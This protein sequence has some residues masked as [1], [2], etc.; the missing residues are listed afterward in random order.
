MIFGQTTIQILY[1]SESILNHDEIERLFPSDFDIRNQIISEASKQ[2]EYSLIIKNDFS[3]FMENSKLYNQLQDNSSKID[4]G[5]E[6]ARLFK[7]LNNKI[8]YEEKSLNKTYLVKDSLPNFKWK[9]LNE[10]KKWGELE[11]KKATFVNEKDSTEIIAWFAP[12]IRI[13]DGPE[14]YN[15]LPGLII[16]LQINYLRNSNPDIVKSY[17]YKANKIEFESI[18]DIVLP[19]KLKILSREEFQKLE[20]NFNQKTIDIISGGVERD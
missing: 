4:F 17:F 13:F 2:R 11:L 1:Q 6:N 9:I 3:V 15:G 19:R 5:N 7:D 14:Y 12:K 20:E 16:E 8:I 18:N 10:K